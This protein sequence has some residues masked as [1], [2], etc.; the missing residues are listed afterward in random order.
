MTKIVFF[1]R[2]GLYT[3][4]CAAGHS[5]YGVEGEDIVCAAISVL[6]TNTIN[7]LDELSKDEIEFG[8]DEDEGYLCLNLKS[9][10]DPASQILMKA[11]VMGLEGIRRDY[12]SKYCKVDY[13]EENANV[14]A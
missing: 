7:A 1:K 14:K 13:K 4:F 10:E 2:D 6:T 5:G 12:G 8:I 9:N 11:L 3:G